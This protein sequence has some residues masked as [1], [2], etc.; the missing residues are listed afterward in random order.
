MKTTKY[1]ALKT[2]AVFSVLSLIFT[3]TIVVPMFSIMHALF[4]EQA[5]QLIFP[6]MNYANGGKITLLFFSVLFVIT[7][8]LLTKRIKTLV[9]KHQNIRLGESILVMLIFYAIVHPIGYYLLLWLQG[10]PVDAL[11]SIMSVIS[12]LFSSFA[13]VILGFVIDWYWKKLNNRENNAVF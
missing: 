5:F 6:E 12:F 10:F 13:F 1:L 7:L 3:F 9:W 8:V 2:G 4:L 11:N